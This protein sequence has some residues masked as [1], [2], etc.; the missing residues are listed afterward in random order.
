MPDWNELAKVERDAI[1]AA[2]RKIVG[3]AK[4]DGQLLYENE[5]LKKILDA[6]VHSTFERGVFVHPSSTSSLRIEYDMKFVP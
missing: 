4:P 3:P 6:R 1:K 2:L 5:I